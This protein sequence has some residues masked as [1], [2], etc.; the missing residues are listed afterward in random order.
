MKTNFVIFFIFFF[1]EW[2]Y[3]QS[4][5]TQ[6]LI[7]ADSVLLVSHEM[8]SRSTNSMVDSAGHT[9]ILPDLTIGGALN[10]KIVIEEKVLTVKE[11]GALVKALTYT[12]KPSRIISQSGCFDPHHAII[13]VKGKKTSFIE[14][15]FH[16]LGF[17]TSKDII[18]LEIKED[19]WEK[20]YKLFKD[21]GF[22]HEMFLEP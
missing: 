10:T 4:S 13:I 2:G 18:N 16:C 7:Q 19:K 3:G 12:Y 22:K 8:T 21:Y 15:C 6:K 17:E 20:L 1:T 5:L 9:V 14:L 11:I